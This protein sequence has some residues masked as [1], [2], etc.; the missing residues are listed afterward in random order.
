MSGTDCTLCRRQRRSSRIAAG[1]VCAGCA[2]RAAALA[3]EP[4]TLNRIWEV[5][6]QLPG[7]V[8]STRDELR[9]TSASVDAKTHAELALAYNDMGLLAEAI[10][11]AIVAIL[12]ST[13]EDFPEAAAW[14]LFESLTGDR[15][16]RLRTALSAC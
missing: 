13:D 15:L 10:E 4:G 7:G 14:V 12:T 5:A 8:A 3:A 1:H 11:E 16:A 9:K 2:R 6:E